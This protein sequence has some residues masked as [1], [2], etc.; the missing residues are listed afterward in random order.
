[1]NI[2][3]IATRLAQGLARTVQGRPIGQDLG[4]QQGTKARETGELLAAAVPLE[5][6]HTNLNS[7]QL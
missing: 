3:S 6:K 1:L 5:I 2:G 4:Q 7:P